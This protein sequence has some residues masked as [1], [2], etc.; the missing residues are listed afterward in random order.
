MANNRL[1]LVYRPTGK[2]VFLGKRMSE[3]W[4]AV[5]DDVKQRIEALFQHIIDN[6]DA[7][8]DDLMLAMEECTA[9][10]PFVNTKWCYTSFGESPLTT[11]DI[12]K[13]LPIS[14]Y[15]TPERIRDHYL[16]HPYVE[17][18]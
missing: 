7:L 3:G 18:R 2:A 8:Q 17:P 10:T 12:E 16:R 14:I 5:P 6:D 1:L 15:D 11:L 13:C 4:Y 9:D